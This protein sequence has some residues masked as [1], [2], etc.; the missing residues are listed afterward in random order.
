MTLRNGT[1]KSRRGKKLVVEVT[2]GE[3]DGLEVEG[4]S[5]DQMVIASGRKHNRPALLLQELF[6]WYHTSLLFTLFR[7]HYYIFLS[8]DCVNSPIESLTIS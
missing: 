1:R 7:E 2:G 6:F 8:L 3:V 4:G 5:V